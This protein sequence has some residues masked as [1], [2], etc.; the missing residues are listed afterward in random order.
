MRAVIWCPGPSMTAWTE[1]LVGGELVI[2]VNRAPIAR[3]CDVWC[4]LDWKPVWQNHAKV[5][6][7]PM[8]VTT[9]ENLRHPN[10][11]GWRWDGPWFDVR[12]IKLEFKPPGA[13]PFWLSKTIHAACVYAA[14]R[15]CKQ[16]DVYGADWS[17][18]ADFD[19]N[20]AGD[21]RSDHRWATERG[22]FETIRRW[23]AQNG[24][25]LTRR[26]C[27]QHA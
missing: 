19:G 2:G 7:K 9:A 12:Q 22:Q 6:G 20:L 3:R 16:I 18:R 24:V 13:A 26:Q 10:Y 8:L 23:F 27:E 25:T 14:Y 17:G 5:I 15:G 11:N 21:D 1:A 4:A